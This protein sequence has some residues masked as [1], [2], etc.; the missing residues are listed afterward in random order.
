MG[1]YCAC[2]LCNGIPLFPELEM[3]FPDTLS[4]IVY[5]PKITENKRKIFKNNL[6]E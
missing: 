1:I 5:F 4:I 3:T 6:K 2:L